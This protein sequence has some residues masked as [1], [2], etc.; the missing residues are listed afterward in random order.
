MAS[1]GKTQS[2]A[3]GQALAD[4]ANRKGI[5]LEGQNIVG[6]TPQ[7]VIREMREQQ[8]L[9]HGGAISKP[10]FSIVFA[11]DPNDYR[12]ENMNQ[13]AKEYMKRF[14]KRLKTHTGEEVDFSSLQFKPWLHEEMSERKV[15]HIHILCNRI[16]PN[17][18]VISDSWIGKIAK[19][20]AEE[21]DKSRK[22]KTAEDIGKDLRAVVKQKAH[23]ALT[24]YAKEAKGEQFDPQ[25]FQEFCKAHGLV[26]SLSVSS[27]GRISGYYLQLDKEATGEYHTKYKASDIDK[28]LTLSR[29]DK[30]FQ[31]EQ[32]RLMRMAEEEEK[33]RRA[34][35]RRKQVEEQIKQNKNEQ[36]RNRG[37]GFHL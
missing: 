2:I 28:R 34:E 14:C 9:H 20:T 25:R 32:L 23:E 6:E 11:P 3:H 10:Y 27:T 15:P 12:S 36:S 17:G 13:L 26:M 4:Y 24:G 8:Q 35:E 18:E 31:A 29:I 1:I 22:L 7:E 19:A 21:M 16:L 30:T 33:K 37:R 5:G